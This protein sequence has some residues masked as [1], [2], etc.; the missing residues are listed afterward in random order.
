MRTRAENRKIKVC[1]E[2]ISIYEQVRN[3]LP[4]G[5][6][7][8]HFRGTRSDILRR[9]IYLSTPPGGIIAESIFITWCPIRNAD[10]G[11]YWISFSRSEIQKSVLL[12]HI[13]IWV[14][15]CYSLFPRSHLMSALV[16]LP[17]LGEHIT[18][19]CQAVPAGPQSTHH[20]FGTEGDA[21]DHGTFLSLS[22][23]TQQL[24]ETFLQKV[25]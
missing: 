11:A 24:L 13:T 23:T 7:V 18:L 1:L 2:I 21:L 19:R 9:E 10:L 14:A 16:V 3:P 17:A 22:V 25:L 15:L 20:S 12:M 6:V 4:S 8:V 5:K